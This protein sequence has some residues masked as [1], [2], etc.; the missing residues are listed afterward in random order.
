M[1]PMLPIR[2]L[3]AGF[4][5]LLVLA[6]DAPFARNRGADGDFDSRRSMH[7]RLSQDV[8]IDQITGAEGSRAFERAVLNQLESAYDEVRRAYDMRPR[9]DTQVW[10]YDPDIFEANFSG[11]FSFSAAGFY[12]RRSGR[13]YVR[14]DTTVDY[15]LTN[16]LHHEYFHAVLDA[17]TD[18]SRVPA[19]FNEGMAQHF[20]G[21]A[22]GKRG[23][24][25]GEAQFLANANRQGTWLPLQRISTPTFAGLTSDEAGLAYLQSYAMV[26]YLLHKGGKNR[27]RSFMRRYLRGGNMNRLLEREFRMDLEELVKN[28]RGQYR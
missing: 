1:T 7:F 24:S 6:P 21:V 13:I 22:I 15:H 25:R 17:V 10:I 4:A 20:G 16:T 14:G 9:H 12:E 8:D 11:Q 3:I 26:E 28:V 19:W 27:M 2:S 23:L 5:L 18:V